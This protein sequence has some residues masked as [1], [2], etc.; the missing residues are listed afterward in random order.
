LRVRL[1]GRRF[2]RLLGRRRQVKVSAYA[3]ALALALGGCA[4]T[5]SILSKAPPTAYDLIPAKDFP[6]RSRPARGQLIIVEPIVLSAYDSEKIVVR[7]NPGETATLADA[8]WQDRLPK[9][10]QA[11][12]LQSFENASRLRAVG[13]P[14]DKL[15]TDFVLV[16]E[17]RAFEISAAD[18]TAVVE[19]AAKIVR[20]R[21]GR[22]MA[23]RVFR[24][25]VPAA[26]NEG[27]GAVASLNEAFAKVET[28]LVLWAARV[29]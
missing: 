27:A 4:G 24:A 10:M 22:I 21:T 2:G 6:H 12:I 17:A 9:L 3:I 19:I 15:T 16:T 8:Q 26:S 5:G 1:F 18:G 20:E 25:T 13:R 28:Q 7:P 29:I 14:A 11:R 23:A